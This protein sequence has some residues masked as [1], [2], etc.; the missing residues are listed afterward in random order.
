MTVVRGQAL[1][2]F[3]QFT[4]TRLCF[5]HTILFWRFGEAHK[6]KKHN[7]F[8]FENYVLFLKPPS[9]PLRRPE[10]MF[11]ACEEVAGPIPSG[12]RVVFSSG[13]VTRRPL[14]MKTGRPIR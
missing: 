11:R 14:I 7:I 9:F 1:T 12:C 8:F 13:Q 10:R 3:Q 2:V 5:S 4:T 6:R